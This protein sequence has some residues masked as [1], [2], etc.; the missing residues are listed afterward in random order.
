MS[1]SKCNIEGANAAEQK[2]A[3]TGLSPVRFPFETNSAH[4]YLRCKKIGLQCV[5]AEQRDVGML[6]QLQLYLYDSFQQQGRQA[7]AQAAYANAQVL[8]Q[9]LC[10]FEAAQKQQ[11]ISASAAA[12]LPGK[13][14]PLATTDSAL[15]Y[16]RK[17]C[18]LLL[19]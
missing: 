7:E 3:A 16:S 10:S 17:P 19:P 15:Q 8:T 9:Q 11:S 14:A 5:T 6:L 2:F 18:L 1:D 13:T 12:P 4:W